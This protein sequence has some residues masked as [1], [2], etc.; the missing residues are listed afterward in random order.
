ME[1]RSKQLLSNAGLQLPSEK[2]PFHLEVKSSSTHHVSTPKLIFKGEEA[3][4][5]GTYLN[6]FKRVKCGYNLSPLTKIRDWMTGLPFSC[7]HVSTSPKPHGKN[8]GSIFFRRGY[9]YITTKHSSHSLP[10][11]HGACFTSI[12]YITVASRKWQVSKRITV[13]QQKKKKSHIQPSKIQPQ[14]RKPTLELEFDPK[15]GVA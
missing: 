1:A 11:S 13:H 3:D 10:F 9:L 5:S 7:P 14:P 4:L 6:Q 15:K 12:F 2:A 8:P